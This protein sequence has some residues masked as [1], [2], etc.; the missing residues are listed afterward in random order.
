MKECELHLVS[1][2]LWRAEKRQWNFQQAWYI[3]THK[4]LNSH[5][6]IHSIARTLSWQCKNNQKKTLDPA[7]II[8]ILRLDYKKQMT[9]HQA[10]GGLPH[11]INFQTAMGCCFHWK[12]PWNSSVPQ[13]PCLLL[14]SYTSSTF[15]PSG[16]LPNAFGFKKKLS[17][18]M[19]WQ[20]VRLEE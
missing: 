20:E 3:Q 10:S 1:W 18:V 19:R 11:C 6:G 17:T 7:Q 15:Q 16:T 13:N 5:L 12:G 4:S 8:L 14:C 2:N 9:W